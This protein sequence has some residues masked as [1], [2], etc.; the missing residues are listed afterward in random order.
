MGVLTIPDLATERAT[1]DAVLELLN[2]QRNV[3]QLGYCVIKNRGADDHTSLCGLILD[4]SKRDMLCVRPEIESRRRICAEHLTAL[5]SPRSNEIPQRQ[6]L[7]EIALRA[8][9]IT[10]SALN[11]YYACDDGL[12]Q[13]RPAF[14]LITKLI[15]LNELFA[16]NFWKNGHVQHFRDKCSDDGETL[17]AAGEQASPKEAED[18]EYWVS[19]ENHPTEKLHPEVYEDLSDIVVPEYNCPKHKRG[20]LTKLIH[21]VYME[22]R[23][24]ALG[25]FILHIE[26]SGLPMTFNHYFNSMAQKN[27]MLTK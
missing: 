9:D 10:K 23:G 1:Q 12:F 20:P 27:A 15:R 8:Q 11:G 26:R 24:P 2:D 13:Q 18:D 14:R 7:V 6:Y 5:G 19:F 3:L 4:V 21:E 25:T 17:L 22:S 16:D